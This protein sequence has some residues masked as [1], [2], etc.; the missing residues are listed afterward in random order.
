[1]PNLPAGELVI[2]YRDASG[3]LGQTSHWTASTDVATARAAAAA[4][5]V[6][7]NAASGCTI[8]TWR[9]NWRTQLSDELGAGPE[10]RTQIGIFI[11]ATTDPEQYAIYT[12][13]GIK[14]SLRDVDDPSGI[15]IDLEK[16]EV[17]QF[18]SII[19]GGAFASP[20]GYQITELKA[21]FIQIDPT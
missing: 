5:A 4:L 6:V 20:Q 7:L 1:M 21:A 12:L 15:L 10:P 8:T 13:P 19:E 9:W 14:D 18:I 11:W 2:S 16:P 17:I 3:S